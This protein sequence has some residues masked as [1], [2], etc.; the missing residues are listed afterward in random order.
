VDYFFYQF[1][2]RFVLGLFQILNYLFNFDFF[3]YQSNAQCK[4]ERP[5]AIFSLSMICKTCSVMVCPL[6]AVVPLSCSA[7]NA[8][9]NYHLQYKFILSQALM[10]NLI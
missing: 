4:M 9:E 7:H 5:A 2:D 10:S 3:F 8:Y 6:V 1:Q